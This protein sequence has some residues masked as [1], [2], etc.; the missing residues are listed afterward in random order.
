MLKIY[1]FLSY[2]LIYSLGGCNGIKP[3]PGD[4]ESHFKKTGAIPS[5]PNYLLYSNTNRK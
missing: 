1:F 3:A 4:N 2:Y 5:E